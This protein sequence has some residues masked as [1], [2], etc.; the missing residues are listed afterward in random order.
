MGIE[1]HLAAAVEAAD[2]GEREQHRAGMIPMAMREHDG[3]DHAEIDAKPRH[4][5]LEGIILRAR[6]EQHVWVLPPR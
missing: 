3:L 4:I 1:R 5:A 2:L 6:V